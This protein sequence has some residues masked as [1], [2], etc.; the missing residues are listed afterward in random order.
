MKKQ[1]GHYNP[2][3]LDMLGDLKV[4][5]GQVQVISLPVKDIVIGMVVDQDVVAKNGTLLVP[6]GQEVTRPI[7][8]GLVNFARK[9]GIIEPVLV[10][11][12][13]GEEQE[14]KQE[15]EA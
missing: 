5:E 10:R 1:H 15:Q 7:I 9:V 11:I 6:K 8:Q 2:Q 3:L 13:H 12:E 4:E 14:H